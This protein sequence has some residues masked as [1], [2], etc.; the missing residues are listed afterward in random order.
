MTA[1]V[2]RIIGEW[3]RALL[4]GLFG[5][6]AT[7]CMVVGLTILEHSVPPDDSTM[8]LDEKVPAFWVL[9]WPGHLW[10][11]VSDNFSF[12]FV[13]TLLTYATV[14]SLAAYFVMRRRDRLTRLS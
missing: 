4:S 2:N 1:A 10:G 7:V 12:V 9:T 5:V 8:S 14:F 6:A 3:W 13:A 11:L